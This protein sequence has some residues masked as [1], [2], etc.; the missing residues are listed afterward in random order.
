MSRHLLLVACVIG[1]RNCHC[2]HLLS[3]ATTAM[4]TVFAVAAFVCIVCCLCCRA[5][6]VLAPACAAGAAALAWLERLAGAA[7]LFSE[8]AC[9]LG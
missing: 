1:K 6:H 7:Q 3:S 9:Y 2:P 8:H 5:G 4:G